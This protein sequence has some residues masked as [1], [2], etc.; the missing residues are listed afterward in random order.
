[1]SYPQ[2][3]EAIRRRP[4]L[5]A[6]LRQRR[7]EEKAAGVAAGWTAERVDALLA[8]NA[9]LSLVVDAA[10]RMPRRTP[11]S[12][13]ASTNHT[14]IIEAGAVWDLDRALTEL[15][16]GYYSDP[17]LV[18]D[19]VQRLFN[20][21]VKGGAIF[22]GDF[23]DRERQIALLQDQVNA[24]A[25]EK[26]EAKAKVSELAITVGEL[27]ADKDRIGAGW[28]AAEKARHNLSM[29]VADRDGWIAKLR[30]PS[31]DEPEPNAE[32][33]QPDEPV[34]E[35]AALVPGASQQWF[36]DE[37]AGRIRRGGEVVEE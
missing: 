18:M 9:I 25:A 13:G 17:W 11:A 20:E 27:R 37:R 2:F 19:L 15:D 30:I 10:R 26:Y 21:S 4:R 8:E 1:M 36:D 22:A 6:E 12:G 23:A 33:G 34:S 7:E 28:A 31:A 35:E 5:I 32:L 14:F 24:L 3:P 16:K 29:M